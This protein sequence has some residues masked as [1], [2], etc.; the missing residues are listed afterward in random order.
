[1]KPGDLAVCTHPTGQWRTNKGNVY[2]GPKKGEVV[3]I[4]DA[5]LR[6]GGHPYYLIVGYRPIPDAAYN[7]SFFTP[8]FLRD[9]VIEELTK[10]EQLEPV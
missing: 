3:E 5:V 8:L 6:H 4:E 7:S 1:M 9:E 2:P 10:I